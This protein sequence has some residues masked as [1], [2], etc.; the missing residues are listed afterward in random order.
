MPDYPKIEVAGEASLIV[1]LGGASSPEVSAGVQALAMALRER[2]AD[3]TEDLIPSYASLLV[4]FD[5]RRTDHDK[6]TA[7]VHACLAETGRFEAYSGR[8]V[9]VPV[10][11]APESGADLEA[12]GER[13]GLGW[14][15]VA[16]LHSSVEYRVYAVGFAPGFAYLGSVDERIAAP[17]LATPRQRVPPGAVAIADRQTAVY[18]SSSPGGW[19][20]IGRSPMCMFDASREE[21]MPVRVGDRVRF[22][23]VDRDRYDA[24]GGAL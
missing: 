24:L 18:P 21:P 20:L 12:L 6:V 14:R 22:V 23:P 7:L 16:E 19:N 1:Y 3:L 8:L 4:L 11:Y 17:R 9:E 13:S 2:L 10:Y 5:P 15:G